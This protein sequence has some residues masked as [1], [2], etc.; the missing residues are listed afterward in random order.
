MNESNVQRSRSR[1][2]NEPVRCCFVQPT[3]S[4]YWSERL[5]CLAADPRLRIT[6][7]LEQATFKHRPGW[8]PEAIP[9][10]DIR[11]VGSAVSRIRHR[12]RDLRFD[13]EGIR[14]VPWSLPSILRRER[15]DVVV[16][17][18]AT[19][20]AL[21]WLVRR[22]AGFVLVAM[23]EDTPHA[24]RNLGYARS[25][26]KAFAYRK[27][28]GWFV[29]SHDARCYLES[30]GISNGVVRS[31]WSVDLS[32]FRPR[33]NEDARPTTLP[34]SVPKRTTVVFVG[35]LITLKGVIP[36]IDAWAQLPR[37]VRRR[38]RLVLYGDGPLRTQV[39]NLCASKGLDDVELAGHIAYRDL[40]RALGEADLFV[41]PTLQDLYGLSLVEAMASGCPVITTPFTGG[42]EL[43][44]EGVNGWIVDPTAPDA[45]RRALARA[46]SS[47]VDLAQMG[48]NARSRVSE[49]DNARVMRRFADDLCSLVRVGSLR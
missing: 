19:Q 12:H 16:V 46:L 47:D 27:A 7:L 17:C 9:G 33:Q 15:P 2:L 40:Q 35:R 34:T 30:I 11:V 23:V 1:P 38:A 41:F 48:L 45:L 5:R 49:M 29:F 42:R 14:T 24:V 37:T 21:A 36:L 13:V 3:Q 18:N 8:I 25:R 31:P 43:V 22:A 26:F 32:S 6:L 4:P 10:V 44:T 28:D 39:A 20:S